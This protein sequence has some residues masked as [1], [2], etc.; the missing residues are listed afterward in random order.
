MRKTDIRQEATDLLYQ[1]SLNRQYSL[2][3]SGG[4]DAYTY[5]LS[6]GL[7]QD[8]SYTVGNESKRLNLNLRNTFKPLKNLELTAAVWYSNQRADNNGLVFD[9]LKPKGGQRPAPYLRLMDDD[10]NALPI[11]YERSFDYYETAPSLGLLDWHYR[12][13]DEMRLSDNWTKSTEYRLNGGL[14]YS[15]LNGFNLNATYQYRISNGNS[16]RYYDPDTYYVRDLVNRFTQD[17]RSFIIPHQGILDGGQLS[18]SLS[19]SARFQLNYNRLISEKHQVNALAGVE[20][21]NVVDELLP[22]YRLYNFNQELYIGTSMY[23]YAQFYKTNPDGQN[24]RL[25]TPSAVKRQYTDR[26]L[27]YF[28]NASY[29]YD[30]RYTLSGSLRWDGSNLFGVKTNQKGVPLWSI[31]GSWLL[32]DETFYNKRWLPYLRFRATYGSSGNVNKNVSVFPVVDYTVDNTTNLLTTSL[33]SVGNPSLRWEKVNTLNLGLDFGSRNNR[34]RSSIE[35]YIKKAS[36]LIGEDYIPSSTGINESNYALKNKINYANITTK[37]WDI[38]LNSLNLIGA[39]SWNMDVLFSYT[40][41]KI[42]HFNTAEVKNVTS[43][44]SNPPPVIGRSHDVIYTLPWYG[45]SSENGYPLV[46]VDDELTQ[47]YNT[48]VDGFTPEDLLIG[49]V[50]IAPYYGSLRNTFRYKQVEL[51]VNISWKAGLTFRRKSIG[52]ADEYYNSGQYHIDYLKRWSKPGDEI[53]TDVPA[54]ADVSLGD[55]NLAYLYSRALITKGDQVRLQDVNIS[56]NLN[57]SMIQKLPVHS[58]RIY[59][60]ARNLGLLWKANKNGIDPDYVNANF[61]APKTFALG[62]QIDF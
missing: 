19:E 16:E 39:F 34:L 14:K 7:D 17:N 3:I 32:S 29:T 57:N 30:Q 31:G 51:S 48:F 52:P 22:G 33:R 43:Y 37:G 12:P 21:R 36:D 4:G 1:Q 40:N 35:H 59:G 56:Y 62:L 28:G 25:P 10:G 50:I 44:L 2:N 55:G 9:D 13:L 49:G 60:Y 20:I 5:Y 46:L 6:T 53:Y 58:V 26:Y 11:P 61:P 42:T 24:V 54:W 15:F 27:S 47:D 38:Q 8:R 23:N 41:N 45:L 18:Q